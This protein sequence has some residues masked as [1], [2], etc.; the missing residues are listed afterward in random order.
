MLLSALQGK[1][2][3]S[4]CSASILSGASSPIV[5]KTGP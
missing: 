3:L 4:E 2:L 5:V 1:L